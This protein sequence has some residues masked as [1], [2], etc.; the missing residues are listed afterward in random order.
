MLYRL[1]Y[2]LNEPGRFPPG[3]LPDF[4]ATLREDNRLF[5]V[6]KMAGKLCG[7]G[8]ISIKE[9]SGTSIGWLCFGLIHPKHHGQGIGAA[10]L[11]ARLSL[12]PT[13]LRW[14]A[15]CT[16]PKSR[17]Y[18]ERFNFHECVR[19]KWPDGTDAPVHR[20][21]LPPRTRSRCE[22]LL[23]RAGVILTL[24]T[25]EVPVSSWQ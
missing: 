8:G 9:Q 7:C 22:S 12:L 18:Y 2:L 14:A 5:L 15:M 23:S 25:K 6:A 24:D 21:R 1:V 11:L 13:E 4:E 19:G 20:V 17:G 16:V 10:L 3:V